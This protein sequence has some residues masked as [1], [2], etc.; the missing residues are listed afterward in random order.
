MGRLMRPFVHN[1][2]IRLINALKYH[3]GRREASRGAHRESHAAFAFLLDYVPGWKL[4]YRPIGLIQYQSFIP[5]DRA[6]AAMERLLEMSRAAG[7]PPYLAVFKRHRADEFL[8]SYA[9]DG[10]SLALDY[11]VTPANRDRVWDLAHRMDEVVLEAGGRF[12]FAKDSTLQR[13][14]VERFLP[15][16]RLEAFMALKQRCDP[17]NLLQTEL[18]RRLF[19]AEPA[20]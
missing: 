2:G 5:A 3:A 13:S 8:I 12:Y 6:A 1:P 4:A 14:T 7:L 20:G 16:E 11:R 15:R 10:Y 19:V 18:Y 17:E 9:V